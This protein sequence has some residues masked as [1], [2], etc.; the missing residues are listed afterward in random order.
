MA[1]GLCVLNWLIPGLGFA[2]CKDFRRAG[3]LFVLINLCFAVG[4]FFGGTVL[5]PLSWKPFTAD[6]NVVAILT[7]LSQAFHGSGWLALQALHAAAE[8]TPDAYF[9]LRHMAAKTF[10]DLGSFHLVVAGG[11]NYFA[12]VRLY[13]LLAGSPEMTQEHGSTP[14]ESAAQENAKP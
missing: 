5:L 9:N 1:L 7:Y 12:T 13:D 4:V 14:V 3:V 11:L 10:G 2:L 8:S 6:F